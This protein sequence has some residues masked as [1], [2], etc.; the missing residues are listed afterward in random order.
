MRKK[1]LILLSVLSI[2]VCVAA[3]VW[4]AFAD[5]EKSYYLTAVI[6]IA[7]AILPFFAFFEGRRISTGE[8]VIL[9]VMVTIAVVSRLIFSFV[10]EVKPMA[11]FI[12]V[13]GIAFGANAGF[14]SGATAIFVSNFFMGQ[15]VYTPYQM[16]GMGLVG[17]LAGL[18]FH[19]GVVPKKRVVVAVAG[20]AVVTFIYGFIVD[21]CSVFIIAAEKTLPAVL[22]V[23]LSGLPFNLI[24]GVTTAVVLFLINKPMNDKFDRLRLKYGVFERGAAS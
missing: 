16:L 20:F 7:A 15:G 21:S 18:I 3:T 13:T 22:S 11:A 23:Y 2:A 8:V 9:A 12:F 5:F 6:I 24:H 10:P 17:F 1:S 14:I 19:S 4:A